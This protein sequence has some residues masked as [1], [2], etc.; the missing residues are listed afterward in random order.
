MTVPLLTP[1]PVS[2]GPC[3]Y[4]HGTGFVQASNSFP[5]EDGDVDV[6]YCDYEGCSYWAARDPKS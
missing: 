1:A 6:D 2:P 4:C 5:D 3:P